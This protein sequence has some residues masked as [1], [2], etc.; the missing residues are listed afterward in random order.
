MNTK[1]FV[2]L[3]LIFTLSFVC[4]L[5]HSPALYEEGAFELSPEL[6]PIL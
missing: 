3:N 1:R 2:T 5:N 4:I 6:T